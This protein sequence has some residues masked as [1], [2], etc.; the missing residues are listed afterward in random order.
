MV[1]KTLISESERK[2]FLALRRNIVTMLF[3]VDRAGLT[4]KLI[5]GTLRLRIPELRHG[6]TVNMGFLFR[7]C[8]WYR[9]TAP[10][11]LPNGEILDFTRAEIE[12]YFGEPVDCNEFC[13]LNKSKGDKHAS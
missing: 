10:F 2:E 4:E 7:L 13:G 3:E 5:K 1:S 8:K 6:N 12:A 11:A 9:E